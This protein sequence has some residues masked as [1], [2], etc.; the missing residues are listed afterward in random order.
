MIFDLYCFSL[1]L[2]KCCFNSG[3]SGREG[4]LLLRNGKKIE[5]MQFFTTIL[6]YDR[7]KSTIFRF[8]FLNVSLLISL[9]IAWHNVS[10]IV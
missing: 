1:A 6:V 7:Q 9:S 2:W 10:Y 4:G 5:K 8:S 3:E